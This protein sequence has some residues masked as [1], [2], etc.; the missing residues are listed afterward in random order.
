MA[1]QFGGDVGAP[2]VLTFQAADARPEPGVGLPGTATLTETPPS[3][4]SERGFPETSTPGP[5]A[6]S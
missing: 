5:S 1:E 4:T 2:D 3:W 6:A